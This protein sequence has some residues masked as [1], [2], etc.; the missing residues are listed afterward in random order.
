MAAFECELERADLDEGI[1][2]GSD[3]FGNKSQ[4]LIATTIHAASSFR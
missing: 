3:H 4:E 2:K 1:V